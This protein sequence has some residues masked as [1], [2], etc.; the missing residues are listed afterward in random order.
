MDR[1][2]KIRCPCDPGR[3]DTGLVHS[4]AGQGGKPKIAP[5]RIE[6][7]LHPAVAFGIL[8]LFAFA[9]TGVSLDGVSWSSLLEPAPLGIAAGLFLGKQYG[10]IGAAWM[11]VKLGWAGLPSGA[12]WREMYGVAVLCG[13]GFTMSLFIS[14]LAFEQ[15]ATALVGDNRL[16]ILCGSILSALLGYAV[17]R[18]MPDGA[19]QRNEVKS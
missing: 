16:G 4:T 12:C 1:G 13:I 3:R 9:N 14:S 18:S 17:L 19:G 5:G 6:H 15:G 7:D 2:V 11:V 10:V 8:P